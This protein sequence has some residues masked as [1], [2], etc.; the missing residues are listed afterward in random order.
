MP[1]STPVSVLIVGGGP[2][3][4]A[5]ALLLDRF[6]IDCTVIEKSPTTTDHP[7]SRGCWVRT[8]EI[9]RQWGIEQA[10]RDRGLQESSDVFV[11]LDSIA[12]HEYGRTRPEPNLG[13]TPA[14]KSLVAQDAV[15]EEILKVVQR[16]RHARVLFSTEFVGF[17]ETNDGVRVETRAVGSGEP[18]VWTARYLIAADGA[19]SSTRRAAGIDMV[20]PATL[21]VMSNEYWRA[22][23][24]HLPVAREAAGFMVIPDRPE[25]PRAGILNT[26]GRDRWLTVTQIGTTTDER[27]RP[28]TDEEFIEIARA[29]AGIPDLDVT[30]INR[31]TW[32]VSM[33]VAE[34]FRKGRVFIV[35]DAAHRF[36]PTG[37]FGLN[38]GVQDAHNL[39]WKLA[40]VLR[41]YADDKLL[42]SYSTER[43]PVAQSNAAFSYGNRLRIGLTDDAIRSRNP[44]RIRFW[45]NDM[46]NHLHSIGQNLGHCYEDGAVIP[47]GTVGKALNSRHY[48]PTDRPGG[49]FPHLWLDLARQHST[50]DWFDKDFV[51]VA[52]PAADDWLTA[53]GDVAGKLDVPLKAERLPTADPADGFQIGLRG[54]ALVRPDGHVAWRMPWTPPDPARELA[55]AVSALLH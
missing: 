49:R 1:E 5:T 22:D 2:V 25:V 7:K 44:D 16:S 8:M 4:L 6:G 29:H 50:L 14:W 24:S 39:A 35:G 52:G 15:E 55:S 19:G 40:F 32:R 28:W 31:S 46:D 38:S 41:G 30:L 23:L 54:A 53:A 43:R 17:E 26:N 20:G 37:G 18:T 51:L 27:P 47:D 34:T 45:I 10:I 11:Y 21:A 12:G 48:T 9:F 33:Q 13:Q 36:P 3:G 42:D